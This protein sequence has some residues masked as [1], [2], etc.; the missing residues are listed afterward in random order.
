[1]TYRVFVEG[2]DV[3]WYGDFASIDEARTRGE[4]LTRALSLVPRGT[5]EHRGTSEI[6]DFRGFG[7]WRKRT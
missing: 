6:W 7:D 2:K 3:L 4:G 1:M 5:I